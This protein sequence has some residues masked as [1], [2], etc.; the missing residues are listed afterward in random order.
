MNDLLLA[1]FSA[2]IIIGMLFVCVRLKNLRQDWKSGA[3]QRD[4]DD[5]S[6]G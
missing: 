2:A 3:F 5:Y 1:A 4:F 6:Q